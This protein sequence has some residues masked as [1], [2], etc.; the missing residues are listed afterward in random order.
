MFGDNRFEM[1][2]SFSQAGRDRYRRLPSEEALR[3]LEVRAAHFR[4]ALGER[5][6]PQLDIRA[7]RL[8]HF[9]GDSFFLARPVS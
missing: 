5:E 7:G 8:T 2:D 9:L 1:L 4:V 6:D 3:A